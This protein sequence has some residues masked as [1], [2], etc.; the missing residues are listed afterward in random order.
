MS[1]PFI[2]WIF[3]LPK[4]NVLQVLY[5]QLDFAVWICSKP[6]FPAVTA[7]NSILDKGEEKKK[8]SMYTEFYGLCSHL[9]RKKGETKLLYAYLFIAV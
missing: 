8:K 3:F 4:K 7:G 1:D 2:L 6:S 9:H 5:S